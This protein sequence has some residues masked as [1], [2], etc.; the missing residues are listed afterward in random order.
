MAQRKSSDFDHHQNTADPE[1]LDVD[2]DV[3]VAALTAMGIPE[4]EARMPL[5]SF[6]KDC[7]ACEHDG[8]CSAR[9]LVKRVRRKLEKLGSGDRLVKGTDP[10]DDERWPW[11]LENKKG[12]PEFACCIETLAEMVDAILDSKAN[13]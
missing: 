7:R 4:K 13:G 10:D 3:R 12:K 11:H 2:E 8:Q 5:E 9:P 1:W 6:E